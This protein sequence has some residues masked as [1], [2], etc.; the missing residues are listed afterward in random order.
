ML[1]H[2][3][4]TFLHV[5]NTLSYTKTSEELHITQPAVTQHI[6]YLE[7]YYG[8]SLFRYVNRHLSLTEKGREL[9]DYALSMSANSKRI[10]SAMQGKEDAPPH[11]NFGATRTIG[12]FVMPP[13]LCRYM[14]QYPTANLHMTVDNTDALL[15]KLRRGTLD[16]AFIEGQFDKSKYETRLFSKEPFVAVCSPENP[17]AS[18][19]WK[20]EDLCGQRLIL[21]E[22]GSGSRVIFE[23]ILQESNMGTDA[24]PSIMEI[25]NICAIKTMVKAGLGITF[26]YLEAVKEELQEGS[27]CVIPLERGNFEREFNLVYLKDGLMSEEYLEFFEK[28]ICWRKQQG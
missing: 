7:R 16:F 15:S 21:R 13:L 20:M 24:F 10:F 18:G 8:I 3:I 28:C 23:Q 9:R 25:G 26:L 27:L 17:L 11:L 6:K 4:E 2:R 1:D 12:E 19:S 5:C 22:H 14:T